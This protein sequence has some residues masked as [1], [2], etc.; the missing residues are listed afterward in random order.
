MA[1]RPGSKGLWLGPELSRISTGEPEATSLH[2]L[3]SMSKGSS[4]IQNND[5][6]LGTVM[7]HMALGGGVFAFTL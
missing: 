1:A 2:L 7:K 3:D 5:P 6:Q 4:D